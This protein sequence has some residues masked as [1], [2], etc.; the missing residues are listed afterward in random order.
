MNKEDKK[1]IIDL[2]FEVA[3]CY[4]KIL[5]LIPD[6]KN[7]LLKYLNE[8]FLLFTSFIHLVADEKVDED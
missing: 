7:N 5:D 2:G 3:I 8:S 4:K 6:D 1:K